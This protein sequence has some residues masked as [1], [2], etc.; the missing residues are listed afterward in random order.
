MGYLDSNSVELLQELYVL[1]PLPPTFA[2]FRIKYA[3][4]EEQK[5]GG[6]IA[7]GKWRNWTY[8]GSLER[9]SKGII[10]QTSGNF[11]RSMI[12]VA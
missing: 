10:I 12:T 8:Y 6:A 3:T 4:L 2:G 7:Q 9:W 1:E 11:E 5:K